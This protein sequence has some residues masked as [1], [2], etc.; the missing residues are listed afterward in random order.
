MP[1]PEI[2]SKEITTPNLIS[3]VNKSQPHLLY[4]WH[5]SNY[6]WLREE[7]DTFQSLSY[8][9]FLAFGA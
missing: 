6:I 9:K 8:S 4:G 1:I 2:R 3:K 5:Y 7:N